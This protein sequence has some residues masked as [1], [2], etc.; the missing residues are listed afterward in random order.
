[1]NAYTKEYIGQLLDR[2]MNGMTTLE[3]EAVLAD[4]FRHS[5]VREEWTAYKEMFA[6]FDGGMEQEK[7]TPKRLRQVCFAAA[8]IAA[9]SV[10]TFTLWPRPEQP[11][12]AEVRKTVVPPPAKQDSA[13]IAPAPVPA[14]RS[15][16][17][18]P[19]LVSK[20]EQRNR[21]PVHVHKEEAL[22][23]LEAENAQLKAQLESIQQEIEQIREQVFIS[24]MQTR[25][26]QAVYLEDGNIQF[27]SRSQMPASVEL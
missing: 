10:L 18:N 17:S 12:V 8:A 6:Y 2:F 13:K 14:P 1:M 11:S 15:L 22:Q 24:E 16:R 23:K 20:N 5:A 27:V 26:Y 21:P 7:P 9:L 4:Y 25:G 19:R 3:E